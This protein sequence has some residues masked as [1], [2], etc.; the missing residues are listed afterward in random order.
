MSDKFDEFVSAED[1]A[2]RIKWIDFT[3]CKP[4]KD[5]SYIICARCE[6][7]TTA[8]WFDGYQAFMNSDID[9]WIEEKV[10]HW[11]PLPKPPKDE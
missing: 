1:G 5:G 4:L 7:V 6:T 3:L 11:M 2:E 8:Q 10:T 9:G